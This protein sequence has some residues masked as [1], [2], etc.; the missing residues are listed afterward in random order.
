MKLFQVSRR[1]EHKKT[2]L[3]SVV[4]ATGNADCACGEIY[5]FSDQEGKL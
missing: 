1:V 5:N 2:R 4:I 3:N